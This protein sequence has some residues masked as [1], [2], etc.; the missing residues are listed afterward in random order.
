MKRRVK[1]MFDAIPGSGSVPAARAAEVI[2][3]IGADA[4]RCAWCSATGNDWGAFLWRFGSRAEAVAF[5]DR[6]RSGPPPYRWWL[7]RALPG[8]REPVR[9]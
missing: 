7:A 9:V 1:T 4:D 2:A 5:V 6:E 3:A 8:H